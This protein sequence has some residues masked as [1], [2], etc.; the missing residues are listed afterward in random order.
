MRDEGNRAMYAHL[1]AGEDCNYGG[2][3]LYTRWYER[4]IKMAHHVARIASST[5]KR[6]LVIIGLRG[7]L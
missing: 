3:D 2:A 5:D 4:N 6:V 7:S 1:I